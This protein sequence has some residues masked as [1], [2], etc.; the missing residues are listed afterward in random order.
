MFSDPVGPSNKLSCETGSFSHLHNP[1]SLLQPEVLRLY[2]STPE[3]WVSWSVLLPSCSSWFICTRMW[4]QLVRWPL[5]CQ[6]QST[7]PR[8]AASP[9]CPAAPPTSLDVSSLTPRLSDFQ[10]VQFSGSFSCFLFLN[11]LLSFFWLCEE[12]KCIYPCLHLGQKS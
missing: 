11:L 6:P 10:T 3:P 12:E 1:H 2:F 8:L 9:L 7:S 5:T 4:D